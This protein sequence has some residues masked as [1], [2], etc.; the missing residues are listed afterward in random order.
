MVLFSNPVNYWNLGVSIDKKNTPQTRIIQKEIDLNNLVADKS[1]MAKKE[2]GIYTLKTNYFIA[3]QALNQ[4]ETNMIHIEEP[5]NIKSLILNEKYFEAAK[6]IININESE[7][8]TE[9]DSIEDYYYWNGFIY[10]HLG[11]YDAAY[12]NIQNIIHQENP[13]IL[14]LSALIFREFNIEESNL[15][16]EK[17]ITNFPD[18]DYAN[19]AKNLLENN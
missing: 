2:E 18:N 3:P 6:Q 11:N 12:E 13:Q 19:Y 10:Y 5:L 17:I 16:L 4:S 7:I 1:L 15:I 8:L 9:F 14:F